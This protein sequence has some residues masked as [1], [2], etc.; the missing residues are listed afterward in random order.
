L[1]EQFGVV[2]DIGFL[3]PLGALLQH[4][5]LKQLG[6]RAVHESPCFRNRRR[7]CSRHQ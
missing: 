1:R 4:A 3:H 5:D 6:F 2:G 7:R